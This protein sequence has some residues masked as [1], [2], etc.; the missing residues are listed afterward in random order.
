MGR[1]ELIQKF[2]ASVVVGPASLFTAGAR[3]AHRHQQLVGQGV[4]F[5]RKLYEDATGLYFEN[6]AVVDTP[7][8][9]RSFHVYGD[10]YRHWRALGGTYSYLGYPLTEEEDFSGGGRATSFEHGEIYWYSDIGAIDMREIVVA[11]VGLQC[12]G[13]TGHGR[14]DPYFILSSES[15][16]G[17]NTVRTQ[18]YNPVDGDSTR[19]DYIELYRGKPNGVALTAILME[20]DLGNPDAYKAQVE[21]TLQTLHD[22]GVFA[23]GMIPIV[24]PA[25]AVAVDV[26]LGPFVAR[27]AEALNEALGTGDDYVGAAAIPLNGRQLVEMSAAPERIIEGVNAKME[28]PLISGD[29]GSYKGYFS[30][31]PVR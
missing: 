4:V 9:F 10:I 31:Y 27:A 8:E 22:G 12:F 6:G 29:G 26:I 23:L 11:Y 16:A 7:S 2:P 25:L 20:H 17:N 14:D 30:V 15:P 28:S 24:G 13:T 3:L 1:P 5:D 19:T 21:A 18:V